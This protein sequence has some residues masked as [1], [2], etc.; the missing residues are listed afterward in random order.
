LSFQFKF[1]ERGQPFLFHV[2]SSSSSQKSSSL[3]KF[4]KTFEAN[5]KNNRYCK[6]T[7]RRYSSRMRTSEQVGPISISNYEEEKL[8]DD[9]YNIKK[10]HHNNKSLHMSRLQREGPHSKQ[11]V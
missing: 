7:L 9:L 10:Q 2:Y 3:F 8:K 1:L 11:E 4:E 6:E 5:R